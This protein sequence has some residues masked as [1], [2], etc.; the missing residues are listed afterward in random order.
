MAGSYGRAAL[1]AGALPHHP[2]L[3]SRCVGAPLQARAR[4]AWARLD[5]SIFRVEPEKNPVVSDRENPAHDR[6]TERVGSQFWVGL[7]P[8][9]GLDRLPAHFTV[10][11]S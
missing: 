6:P 7:G 8:G 2:R 4:V 3:R 10:K 11:N 1:V 5:L 9:P